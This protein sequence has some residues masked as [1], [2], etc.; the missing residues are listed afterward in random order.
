MSPEAAA[1]IAAKGIERDK[2]VIAFPR[3]LSLLARLH[4]ML[5]DALRR[6]LMRWARFT[7]FG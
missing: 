6:W 4:G 2:S 3:T 5:P 1:E 7:V